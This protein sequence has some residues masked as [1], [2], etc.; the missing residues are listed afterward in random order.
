MCVASDSVEMIQKDEKGN[1]RVC[2]TAEVRD[3]EVKLPEKFYD[4]E[5]YLQ[6]TLYT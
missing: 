4:E 1:L 5:V 3:A 6:V 2:L